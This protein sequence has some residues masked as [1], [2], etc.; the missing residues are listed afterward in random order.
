[1]QGGQYLRLEVDRTYVVRTEGY[2]KVV[3]AKAHQI[4]G[5]LWVLVPQAD[6]ST[7]FRRWKASTQR[8]PAD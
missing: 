5:E 2:L 1:M 3:V 6:G 7:G 8:T 4:N